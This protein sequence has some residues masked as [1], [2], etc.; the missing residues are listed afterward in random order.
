MYIFNMAFM[1]ERG[2][3]RSLRMWLQEVAVPSLVMPGDEKVRFVE[4][5]EIEG[6]PAS[7][8]EMLSISFQVNF[9]TEAEASLWGFDSVPPLRR[10]LAERFGERVVVFCT[11]LQST[12]YISVGTAGC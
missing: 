4:V 11:L 6:V 7:Q 9:K 5:V 1:T 3:E 12:D 2:N 10:L 8:E